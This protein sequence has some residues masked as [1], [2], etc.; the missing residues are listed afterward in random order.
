MRS[1]VAFAALALSGAFDLVAAGPCKPKSSTLTG[2]VTETATSVTETNSVTETSSGA[3][4]VTSLPEPPEDSIIENAVHGGGLTSLDPFTI[5]GGVQINDEDGLTEDGSP[6]TSAAQLS[7]TSASPG[8]KRQSIGDVAAL[9]QLLHNL[10]IRTRYTV[11]FFYYVLTPP[12]ATTFCTLEA[13][14]GSQQFYTTFIYST[15]ASVSYNQV[16]ESTSVPASQASLSIRTTCFGGGSAVVLVDSIFMSNQVTVQNIGNYRL[17]FGDGAP[18]EPV[19]Q[20]ATTESR[21]VPSATSSLAHTAI[22]GS[23]SDGVS[24]RSTTA[25]VHSTRENSGETTSEPG[26]SNSEEPTRT[27]TSFAETT[28]GPVDTESTQVTTSSF[29]GSQ[30]T[31]FASTSQAPTESET[32]STTRDT[33][34]ELTAESTA[35]S[36]VASTTTSTESDTTETI[37]TTSSE[38]TANPTG[39]NVLAESGPAA[40]IR[41]GSNEVPGNILL[42]GPE[43]GFE[44]QAFRVDPTSGWLLSTNGHKL[45]AYNHP[46]YNTFAVCQDN[47]PVEVPLYCEQPSESPGSKLS[48]SASLTDC[49]WQDSSW[50]C[51]PTGVTYTHFYTT[52][53]EDGTWSAVIGPENV[54]EDG[55]VS[56]DF[57]VDFV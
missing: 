13:Y 18:R 26:Q 39:F 36:A 41:L 50:A 22:T 10:N 33:T 9:A 40:N 45:C 14:L 54:N 52:P 27:E 17:D 44:V 34:T 7:A 15:G 55:F 31:S 38:A 51:T 25:A 12:G 30:A 24:I 23:A 49:V 5:T 4:D 16:L 21:Q 8:R 11:Q 20:P 28:S 57:L 3:V 35:E 46:N 2:S 6:D 47:P 37:T 53:W 43:P 1:V 29:G 42:F 56:T 48:C 32:S 19:Q